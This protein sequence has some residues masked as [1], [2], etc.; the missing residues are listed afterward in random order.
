CVVPSYYESFGLVALESLACGTPVVATDVGNHR[1]VIRQGETGYVVRDNSPRRLAD[2]I[3]LLLTG[4]GSD[5]RSASS[6]RASVGGFSW[7]NT[8][9][10]FLREC[11]SVLSNSAVSSQ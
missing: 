2:G 1:S 6:I 10:A 3:A 9:E 4:P 5:Q 7:S 8:A 11:R